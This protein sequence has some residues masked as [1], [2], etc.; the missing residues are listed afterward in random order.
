[1][2]RK[3]VL[4]DRLGPGLRLVFC[5]TAAGRQS[6]LQ[7]A[8]YAHAQNRF[9]K[10]LYQVGLTPRLY[11]PAEYE[12]LWDLGIGL[13]DIAKF[14]YGMDHQLPVGALGERAAA[15]LR[16][17][18]AKA[19]P[20]HLAFTSLNAGRKVMGAKA[21]AGEQPQRLGETRV[22]ILPSPSPPAANH[23]DIAPW[24]ALAEAVR[25]EDVRLTRRLR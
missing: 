3:H 5:G 7:G 20:A 14:A 16:A 21:I 15:A 10:T 19:A 17:R 8:Y 12:S 23:W 18:I 11:A 4:P 2:A 6:A 22:W 13:T 24:R 9:W 1:M 25:A